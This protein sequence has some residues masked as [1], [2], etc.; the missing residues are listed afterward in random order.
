MLH[1]LKRY[2]FLYTVYFK[3]HLKVMMEYKVDFLI[4]ISSVFIQQFASIFFIKVVF[5]HIE[6]LKGWNFYQIL[7]IYGIAFAGRAIHH[8]FFDNLWTIGWQYIRTGNLDRLL[9]RPIN[10]LFQIVAER[11]QQDGFGQL[12]IGGIILS[13][14]TSHL[15][16]SMTIGN[17]LMLLVMI[18]SSG[19]IFV[20]L[21]L[22]FITFSFWMTDSLPVVSAVFSLS[23]FSRYPITIYNKVIAFI[24]TFIIP[25]SFTSFYPAAFFFDKGYKW[26]SLCTP[27]VAIILCFIAYRFWKYGLSVFT[28]TGS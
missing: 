27:L 8:I 10:P 19:F 1:T 5:D 16:I 9:I 15:N 14:S 18:I 3:Q 23:D 17:V 26:V 21:N 22:F 25:Y 13:Y 24:L 11:V 6:T 4:G 28:S 2:A 7:L 20:A 12:I